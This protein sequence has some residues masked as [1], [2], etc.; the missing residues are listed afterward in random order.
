VDFERFRPILERAAGRLRFCGLGI[1]TFSYKSHISIDSQNGIIRH[2][3]ITECR[4]ARARR[5]DPDG[6]LRPQRLSWYRL[7]IRRERG[8]AGA[9]ATITLANMAST[10]CESLLLAPPKRFTA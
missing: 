7:P 1:P 4:A 3:T 2:Q 10:R 8:L 6:E 9:K 5:H